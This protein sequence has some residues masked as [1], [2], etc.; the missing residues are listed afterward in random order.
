MGAQT[1]TKASSTQTDRLG[2]PDSEWTL[3]GSPSEPMRHGWALHNG[4]STVAQRYMNT[5]R[6]ACCETQEAWLRWL[7]NCAGELHRRER[8]EAVKK[9]QHQQAVMSAT[10]V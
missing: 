3:V 5:L 7:F 4:V 6:L 1:L 9:R 10:R 8:G 2:P